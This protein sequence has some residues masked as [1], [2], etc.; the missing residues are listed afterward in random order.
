MELTKPTLFSLS[1]IQHI[2]HF[3]NKIPATTGLE[4]IYKWTSDGML[5]KESYRKIFNEGNKQFF[6][7]CNCRLGHSILVQF[8]QFSLM[9]W[10]DV[11]DKLLKKILY[12][13]TTAQGC[14]IAPKCFNLF[15]GNLM[16]TFMLDGLTVD[17]IICNFF[18]LISL[19]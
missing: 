12:S 11:F 17:S 16:I 5:C 2:I 3:L 14:S 6:S 4:K 13:T 7:C 18:M 15:L 10:R 1:L 8:K 19:P 9:P